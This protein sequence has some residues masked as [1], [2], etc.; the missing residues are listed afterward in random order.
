M[1]Y[2]TLS[3]LTQKFF[4]GP[5]GTQCPF[6]GRRVKIVNWD[7][8]RSG[9]LV[10]KFKLNPFGVC[11]D[12]R[13]DTYYFNF[14]KRTYWEAHELIACL[15]LCLGGTKVAESGG[16]YFILWETEK[17]QRESSGFVD[18]NPIY[19]DVTDD[20]WKRCE[21]LSFICP[22]DEHMTYQ[23]GLKTI[24]D[25]CDHYDSCRDLEIRKKIDSL[26][27]ESGKEIKE[28]PNSWSFNNI[29]AWSSSR[30]DELC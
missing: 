2:R 29:M 14:T 11:E 22:T 10:S 16:S 7:N 12:P 13:D 23:D 4:S 24:L 30:P 27:S 20:M 28:E 3:N 19:I 15:T 21:S 6:L 26:K 8:E 9:L 25:S 18:D 5:K 17:E 1:T